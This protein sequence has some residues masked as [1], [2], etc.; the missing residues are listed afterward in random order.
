MT[1]LDIGDHRNTSFAVELAP[2]DSSPA[3]CTPR[4]TATVTITG[5]PGATAPASAPVTPA[6]IDTYHNGTQ[7]EYKVTFPSPVDSGTALKP[8]TTDKVQLLRTGTNPESAVL[9]STPANLVVTGNYEAARPARVPLVNVTSPTADY[10]ADY[11]PGSASRS[12]VNVTVVPADSDNCSDSAPA[13]NTDAVEASATAA[14]RTETALFGEAACEWQVR[15]ANDDAQ[16]PVTAQLKQTD[17]SSNIPGASATATTSSTITA[18][19]YTNTSATPA[20]SISIWVDSNRRVRSAANDGGM[21]VGSIEFTVHAPGM[22]TSYIA[23]P[24]ISL[25]VTDTAPTTHAGSIEVTVAPDGSHADCTASQT[26]TVSLASQSTSRA[27]VAFPAPVPTTLVHDPVGSRTECT[28]TA[29]FPASPTVGSLTFMRDGAATDDL[30]VSATT[31]S[32]SYDVV[33]DAVVTIDNITAATHTGFASRPNVIVT[34]AAGT[35]CAQTAPSGITSPF[36]PSTP[37]EPVS[38]GQQDCQWVVSYQNPNSDC[39]VEVALYEPGSTTA[40]PSNEYAG[41]SAG[42]FV[43]YTKGRRVLVP[44][45]PANPT[46]AGTKVIG[47]IDFNVPDSPAAT[48][49][50]FFDGTVELTVTD[51]DS[52]STARNHTGN[53][54]E[55]GYAPPAGRSDCSPA[56]NFTVALGAVSQRSSATAFDDDV[57]LIDVPVGATACVYTVT[58]DASE[59]IGTGG[60]ALTLERDR[61]SSETGTLSVDPSDAGSQSVAATYDVQRA[62]VVEL[63]NITT[64]THTPASRSGVEVT[65][66]P[67]GS[68]S[69]SAPTNIPNPLATTSVDVSVDLGQASC[70][71]T[72]SYENVADDCT[73]NVTLEDLAG[74]AIDSFADS[75]DG[76]TTNDG[77]F[78]LYVDDLSKRRLRTADGGGGSVVGAI[79]FAVPVPGNDRDETCE[80]KFDQA[81]SITTSGVAGTHTNTMIQVDVRQKVTPPA[82]ERAECEVPSGEAS[83]MVPL[84]SS[85]AG[86]VTFANLIDKPLG[87]A[88]CEYEMVLE[89]RKASTA[90]GIQLNLTSG[91]PVAF[92]RASIAGVTKT[93]STMPVAATYEAVDSAILTLQNTTADDT[94]HPLADQLKVQV[95]FAA[96]PPAGGTC[97]ETAPAAETVDAAD[98]DN[99]GL[100]AQLCVWTLSFANLTSD[101][102]VTATV[103]GTGADP[104]DST[105]KA[106]LETVTATAVT[107]STLQLNVDANRAVLQ[108]ASGAMEVSSVDFEVQTASCASVFEATIEVS[109]TDIDNPAN[110][111]VHANTEVKVTVVRKP[112]AD[113]QCVVHDA[114]ADDNT[115]V[116]LTLGSDGTATATPK[117]KLVDKPYSAPGQTPVSCEY[118]VTFLR[119]VTSMAPGAPKLRHQGDDDDDLTGELSAGAGAGASSRSIERVYDAVRDAK[120]TLE[121]ITPSAPARASHSRDNRSQVNVTLTHTNCTRGHGE[122][123]ET[124]PPVMI[125]RELGAAGAANAS[126]DVNLGTFDCDWTVKFQNPQMDCAISAELFDAASTPQ[127]IASSEETAADGD[128]SLAMLTR[129]RRVRQSASDG[130]MR[131]GTIKFDVGAEC[132]TYFDG[133]AKVQVTD[134]ENGEHNGT[135]FPV[136]IVPQTA[137]AGCTAADDAKLADLKVSLDMPLSGE[138]RVADLVNKPL[139][140]TACAYTVTFTEAQVASAI[141]S[142]VQLERQGA[143]NGVFPLSAADPADATDTSD[144]VQIT[145]DAVRAATFR[146]LNSTTT[147]MHTHALDAHRRTVFVTLTSSACDGSGTATTPAVQELAVSADEPLS[148]GTDACTWTIA[149]RNTRSDCKVSATPKRLAGDSG[150]ALAA[151]T[152]GTLTLYTVGRRVRTENNAGASS[153][154][155]GSLEF[156]VPDT[157][158]SDCT[159]HFTASFPV[160]ITDTATGNRNHQN[161]TIDIT[162][163]AQGSESRCIAT[164]I[165]TGAETTTAT[166]TLTSALAGSGSVRLVDVPLGGSACA[167]TASFPLLADSIQSGIQLERKASTPATATVRAATSQ[168]PNANRVSL[169]YDAVR[170][171][172]VMLRNATAVT[173]SPAT[174]GTVEVTLTPSG[175]SGAGAAPVQL[176]RTLAA[177]SQAMTVS[178][179]TQSCTWTIAATNPAVDCQVSAQLKRADDSTVNVGTAVNPSNGRPSLA[180]YTVGRR[181]RSASQPSATEVGTVEFAVPNTPADTCT[182]HFTGTIEVDIT[183]TRSG[184]HTGTPIEVKVAPVFSSSSG[185]AALDIATG[186]AISA[187]TVTLTSALKGTADVRLVDV[188]LNQ[189][190]CEYQ[191]V[192]EADETSALPAVEL[193]RTSAATARLRQDS[194]RTDGTDTQT[195]K[196]VYDA[197]RPAKLLLH[198]TTMSAAHTP[199]TRGNVEVTLTPSGCVAGAG[200]DAAP[201]AFTETLNAGVSTEV[202]LGTHSCTWTI[203][204]TNTAVDCRVAALLKRADDSTASIGSAVNPSNGRPSLAV[205]TVGRRVRS[206]SQPSATEVGTVEFAVPDTPE[207]TCTTHFTGTIEVEV[208]DTRS[209]DHRNTPIEVGVAPVTGASRSCAVLDIVSGAAIDTVTVTL[210]QPRSGS[211]MVRLVDVPLNQPQCEYTA[212]F[213]ADETSTTGVALKRTSAATARLRQDGDRT[214]GTDTQTAEVTYDAVRPAQ[215]MLRNTTSV[216]HSPATRGNVEVTLTPSRCV[217]GAGTDAAPSAIT[218]MLNAGSSAVPVLL[219]THSCTWTIAASNTAVDCRVAALLK[220]ADDSTA[221]IGSAVNPSNGR[222]SLAVYTVGRRVRSQNNA[223]S[224]SAEVG[225]VE[226]SVPNT[227]ADTCT[228]H[229]NGTIEIDVT[230][231]RSGA[232]SNHS[233]STLTVTVAPQRTDT[234]CSLSQQI[235]VTLDQPRSGSAPV[236]RLIGTPLNQQPCVYDVS[237]SQVESSVQPGIQLEL[238]SAATVQLRQDTDPADTT[239][240]ELATA[241]YDAVRQAVVALRNA[242]SSGSAHDPA[243]RREVELTPSPG[244]GCTPSETS[245]FSLSAGSADRNVLL[246]FE[247]CA[248]TITFAN[249]ADDCVVSAQLKDTSGQPI[250]GGSSANRPSAGSVTLY[251]NDNRR[252]MSASSGGTEVGSVE[253]TVQTACDTYFDGSL[254]IS[255]TD[256][257]PLDISDRNHAS[258]AIQVRLIPSGAARCSNPPSQTVALNAAGSATAQF[259]RLVNVPA[260]VSASPPACVYNISFPST[261]LSV[262]NLRVQLA[263]T[264]TSVPTLSG[265]AISATLTYKAELIPEPTAVQAVSVTAAQPVT[266]GQP[267]QFTV[268]LPRPAA[269]AVEVSYT[270]AGASAAESATG[271]TTI[272]AGQSSTVISVPTDDDDL[273]EADQTVRVTLTGATGGVPIDQFSRSATG[274]VR[275][276]DPFPTVRLTGAAFDGNRLRFTVELNDPS[277]RDV[278]VSYTAGS[279]SGTVSLLAGQAKAA[280]VHVFDRAQLAP[281]GSLQL[282]L[283]SARNATID[284]N[285]RARALFP[286]VGSWQFNTTLRRGLTPAQIADTLDLGSGWKLYSWSAATQRWVLHTAAAGGTT[287]LP[288]GVTVI[289]RGVKPTAEDLTAAGLGRSSDATL[290]P[291]WN[292]FPPAADAVGLTRSDFAATTAGVSTVLFDPRLTDCRALA[293]VLVI[294]TYDQSDPTSQ[295]GFRLALPCHPQLQ[296]NTGIPAIEA[297]DDNDALYIYFNNSTPA[298]IAF[299]EGQYVPAP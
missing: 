50:T 209:G 246:G 157:P 40:I 170:P 183:D 202:E 279:H 138:L 39:V 28:Y 275:D 223:G 139:N 217:T 272:N 137:N 55:V 287:A 24:M 256:E 158:V 5:L 237:F 193:K 299:R 44:D 194:D 189:P 12:T 84:N 92:D 186:A 48:C 45:D 26:V 104:A 77:M 172:T 184:N 87:A 236:N 152:D 38:F 274:I 74:N 34:V 254:M 232:N 120:I 79:K 143:T 73:V 195:A 181:V 178:L 204:A 173:H 222:P 298:N 167:Y 144:E 17:G 103:R 128:G 69:V 151:D 179:G 156:L 258:T 9:S 131:F 266:E 136:T 119:S 169:E 187:V 245:Q 226:F 19:V 145:Y 215:V 118:D 3:G 243:T 252:T 64:G 161:S 95:S 91:S 171:A 105:K 11:P 123:S 4:A 27:G 168:N 164:D 115:K 290:A 259:T 68:C 125:T 210:N 295:N 291:G 46:Q 261:V 230:D 208:T 35:G 52:S 101:C 235:M 72:V 221:S 203:A 262:T 43:V 229:F 260:S 96:A 276:N 99:V 231:T 147:S 13:N 220:R 185:C 97:T 285:A 250:A 255:S 198:N 238:D 233:T 154:E 30:T 90:T 134:T 58:F 7:C 146:L 241:T 86:T 132:T 177:G 249:T 41:A 163:A 85:G 15:F 32:S 257:L 176:A 263:N 141:S 174:R 281:D 10:S 278:Q 280:E 54:I 127:A 113:P 180:V 114:D 251:V 20:G 129:D 47:S 268:G 93:P 289:F 213:E 297:I 122:P 242:T 155:V 82:T 89:S 264:N 201:Q 265:S 78:T 135:E 126:Q 234:G 62:V 65:L 42:S 153:A 253:F 159:T 108:G 117:P 288:E 239:N 160:T 53:S 162:L 149:Y 200:T 106:V 165:T 225:T 59:T 271:K 247:E 273:D 61:A 283:T 150:A 192:F 293:G 197:V 6:L 33:R 240:T 248:W 199:A 196:V 219:G 190:Q 81:V 182:T 214:D 211:A 140:R 284:V 107:G 294:Y 216:T 244:G 286:V 142:I 70:D 51:T 269:Q 18:G 63:S 23:S 60:S 111:G 76:T 31:A 66:A 25:T 80:T 148:L 83:K 102:L 36:L 270:V 75:N 8:G 37:A 22:C 205:Y 29:T 94:T 88:A 228:T 109:V 292:I 227:P 2:T 49:T 206:A 133:Q 191:A 112:T 277:G 124:A 67:A 218:H 296:R 175:C 16:C 166:A 224:T 56:G 110:L 212:T 121:N 14:D 188:P 267:L 21:Q 57:R 282:R 98:M 116:T 100:G 130:G 207:S 1:D 71:W